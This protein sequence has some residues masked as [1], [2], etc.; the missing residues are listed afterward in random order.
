MFSKELDEHAP[1]TKTIMMAASI[2]KEKKG[3]DENWINAVCVAASILL[4]NRSQQMNAFQLILS[5]IL[6]HCGFLVSYYFYICYYY[7]FVLFFS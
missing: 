6:K 2:C 1:I 5:V 4:R 3:D 7:Y